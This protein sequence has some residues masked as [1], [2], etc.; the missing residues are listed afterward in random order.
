M[1]A[2]RDAP[3]EIV[4]FEYQFCNPARRPAAGAG[5]V[6]WGG[7]GAADRS[8][9]SAPGGTVRGAASVTCACGFA[10]FGAGSGRGV[11]PAGSAS[12]SSSAAVAIAPPARA[13]T[14]RG[15][16]VVGMLNPPWRAGVASAYPAPGPRCVASSPIGA[17]SSHLAIEAS[18]QHRE[19]GH[20]RAPYVR[21]RVGGRRVQRRGVLRLP[22]HGQRAHRRQPHPPYVVVGERGERVAGPAPLPGAGHLR[23]H[24]AHPP[25]RAVGAGV[26]RAPP[27]PGARPPFAATPPPRQCGS[28]RPATT[29]GAASGS[30]T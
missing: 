25:A 4:D 24:L 14:S 5:P 17:V 18:P 29:A 9:T 13:A 20:C 12:P 10:G 23:G 19:R 8:V 27:T 3:G 7:P 11:A 6:H 1:S 16:L 15:R 28:S 30:H 21:L 2:V 22:H 26:S